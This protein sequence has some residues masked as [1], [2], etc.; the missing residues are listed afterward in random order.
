M[1]ETGLFGQEIRSYFARSNPQTRSYGTFMASL[2]DNPSINLEA[3][4]TTKAFVDAYINGRIPQFNE[5]YD[6][7]AA[8]WSEWSAPDNVI[9][10]SDSNYAAIL[11]EKSNLESL[12]NTNG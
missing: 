1:L 3:Y 10:F 6:S 2:R 11:E 7:N 8:F 4:S 5:V 12:I 9:Y